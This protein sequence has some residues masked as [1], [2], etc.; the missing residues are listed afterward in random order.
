[1]NEKTDVML[2]LKY[3]CKEETNQ[4]KWWLMMLILQNSEI[5]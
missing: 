2:L 3:E 5:Q 4:G 1:V